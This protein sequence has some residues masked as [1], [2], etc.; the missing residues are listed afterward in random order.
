M[1]VTLSDNPTPP[2]TQPAHEKENIPAKEKDEDCGCDPPKLDTSSVQLYSGSEVQSPVEFTGDLNTNNEIPSQEML[3]KI[4][5]I[6]VL[7]SE[8]RAVPFK[9]IYTG[10]NVARRVLVIFIRHFFCGVCPLF[11]KKKDH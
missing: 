8:G 11:V 2:E 9:S 7:D 5:D 3:N 10:P 4:A 6:N 1:A